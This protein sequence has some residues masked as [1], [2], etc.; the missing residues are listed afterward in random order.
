MSNNPSASLAALRSKAAVSNRKQEQQTSDR[1]TRTSFPIETANAQAW[2]MFL[3]RLQEHRTALDKNDPVSEFTGVVVMSGI[4]NVSFH[5]VRHPANKSVLPEN[6]REHATKKSF[7]CTFT[8]WERPDHWIPSTRWVVNGAGDEWILYHDTRN[9]SVS[10]KKR[11][12]VYTLNTDNAPHDATGR[13]DFNANMASLVLAQEV[14]ERILYESSSCAMCAMEAQERQAGVKLMDRTV[15]N[16]RSIGLVPVVLTTFAGSE[17]AKD[18]SRG[19]Q[20]FNGPPKYTLRFRGSNGRARKPLNTEELAVRGTISYFEIDTDLPNS[21]AGVNLSSL[22]DYSDRV[23]SFCGSCHD[24]EGIPHDKNPLHSRIVG[25]GMYC[26]ACGEPVVLTE[27]DPETQDSYTITMDGARMQ[28]SPEVVADLMRRGYECHVC[29]AMD[30]PV[31]S[32]ACSTPG[33]DGG[34][35]DPGDLSEFLATI[36]FSPFMTDKGFVVSL[37]PF[38]DPRTN[39]RVFGEAVLSTWHTVQQNGQPVTDVKNWPANVWECVERAKTIDLVNSNISY[40]SLSVSDQAI[41]IGFDKAKADI[42]A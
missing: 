36:K 41:L 12:A 34:Y 1:G 11:G 21:A 19:G 39:R 26:G 32:G 4:Q 33:C 6:M 14:G 2:P 13:D 31:R 18:A 22:L 27:N 7:K 23:A 30:V 28:S 3:S 25:T 38:E 17:A 40:T 24:E 15:T 8:P 16:R 42:G 35:R 10:V 20:K 5:K 9:M 29:G 37:T